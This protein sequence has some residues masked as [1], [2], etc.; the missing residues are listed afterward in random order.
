VSIDLPTYFSVVRFGGPEAEGLAVRL[1]PEP[2]PRADGGGRGVKN[3]GGG[4]VLTHTP[5]ARESA[6]SS[7]DFPRG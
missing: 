2:P 7:I 1:D 5:P 6:G 4:P 3:F